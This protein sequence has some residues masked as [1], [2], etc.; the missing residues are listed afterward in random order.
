MTKNQKKARRRK[1]KGE[2]KA[3]QQSDDKALQDDEKF[4]A[5]FGPPGNGQ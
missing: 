5:P 4:D 2:A 1:M 3:K